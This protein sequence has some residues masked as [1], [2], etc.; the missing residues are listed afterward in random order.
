MTARLQE[1]AQAA[2]AAAH[3]RYAA[4]ITYGL[5]QAPQRVL[6]GATAPEEMAATYDALRRYHFLT[7]RWLPE[8]DVQD[9]ARHPDPAG[10]GSVESYVSASSLALPIQT[11]D[12]LYGALIVLDPVEGDFTAHHH[13]LVASVAETVASG[14][15]RAT[16]TEEMQRRVDWLDASAAVSRQLLSPSAGLM[17]IVQEIADYVLRLS[18]ARSLTIDV[19]SPDDPAVLEVRASAGVGAAKLLGRAYP[20]EASLAKSAMD[21]NRGLLNPAGDL[22]SVDMTDSSSRVAP[23]MV[24]PIHG[25][26]G[27]PRGAIV[28]YRRADQPPFDTVDL[29]M[30]EDFA[31]QTSLALELTEKRTAAQELEERKKNDQSV[32]T[33]NDDTL[34]RLFSIGMIIESAEADLRSSDHSIAISKAES[35]LVQAVDDLN[36]TIRQVR[37]TLKR[38]ATSTDQVPVLEDPPTTVA[39]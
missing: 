24:V 7:S 29:A 18:D 5:D 37:S 22:D 31:R 34:Q 23:A 2:A 28:V 36:E 38:P 35:R 21:Q 15:E 33:A 8:A 19:I 30:A 32:N 39:E 16:A 9:T 27:S 12:G 17:T 6:C 1:A 3:A 11:E 4:V 20:R 25:G 10:A 26:D 14:L 13:A